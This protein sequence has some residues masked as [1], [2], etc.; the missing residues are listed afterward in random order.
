MPYTL[1]FTI[2]IR[3]YS[4]KAGKFKK[5]K[6]YLVQMFF[7]GL[8]NGILDGT[9]IRV[10]VLLAEC[11]YLQKMLL[12][13]WLFISE[14]ITLLWRNVYANFHLNFFFAILP[15]FSLCMSTIVWG[16]FFF[17]FKSSSTMVSY[18][19]VHKLRSTMLF[20]RRV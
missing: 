1:R 17:S 4:E 12:K 19:D 20:C 16:K 2:Q 8:T 9:H 6:P 7:V 3:K 5:I 13:R 15:H 18:G 14:L 11:L 10:K